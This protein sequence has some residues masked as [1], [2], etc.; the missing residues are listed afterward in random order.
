MLFDKRLPA[1]AC[2]AIQ[3]RASVFAVI[4]DSVI[5]DADR[6]FELWEF[7][8]LQFNFWDMYF[9][10]EKNKTGHFQKNLEDIRDFDFGS[11]CSIAMF[12]LQIISYIDCI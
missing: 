11:L 2:S 4:P 8:K 12:F 3:I 1:F 10:F 6:G 5:W 9:R 7:L